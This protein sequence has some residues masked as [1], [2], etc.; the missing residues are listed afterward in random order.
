[1]ARP[2]KDQ[3]VVITGA[4]TGIGREVAR[5]FAAK[6]ARVVL[7]ARNARALESLAEE[8]RAKGGRALPIPT[9][10]TDFAAVERLAAAAVEHFGRLDTWV[11]NAAVSYYATFEQATLDEMRRQVEVNFWGNVHGFKAALP[12][13]KATGG[14]WIS[15][16]SALSDF[17]I[18]LQGTY[19]AVKHALRALTESVRIEFKHAGVPIDVVLI[20]PPSVDTPF[21]EH[22]LTRTGY[23]PKPVA[24]VYD[25]AVIAKRILMA[26]ERPQREVMIGGAAQFFSLVHR[27]APRLFEWHQARF[28]FQGQMTERPKSADG[29]SNFYAPLDEPG[30]VRQQGN[31]WKASWVMWLEEH[32][33]TAT[34]AGSALLAATAVG[35]QR[36]RR[37]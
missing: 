13:M 37:R 18:P 9:D 17:A 28:G 2:L 32:P 10:V 3:V 25:P 22:A 36:A 5:E 34:L 11:N 24:P 12:L 14:V 7:A 20:K 29:L 30:A 27:Y 6:G 31:A 16:A 15:V 21:F 19:C 8:I 4:S 35:W 23:L 1:M 33:K 26:A